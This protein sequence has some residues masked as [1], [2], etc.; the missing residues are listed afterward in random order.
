MNIQDRQNM[1]TLSG[2]II[3]HG[4]LG[5]LVNRTLHFDKENTQAGCYGTDKHKNSSNIIPCHMIIFLFHLMKFLHILL[6]HIIQKKFKKFQW[7][8]VTKKQKT[9]YIL[10]SSQNVPCFSI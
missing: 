6:I 5:I 10:L 3:G 9:R 1:V 7:F 2:N 8:P 4:H